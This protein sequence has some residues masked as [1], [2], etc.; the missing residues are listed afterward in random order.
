MDNILEV[1]FRFSQ[2]PVSFYPIDSIDAN[3]RVSYGVNSG[4]AVNE[5]AKGDLKVPE[6][7]RA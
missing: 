7:V 5:N 6:K 1:A 2:L 3:I 4:R